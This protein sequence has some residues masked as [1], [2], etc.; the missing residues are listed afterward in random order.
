ME[1]V[2]LRKN[3]IE[4]VSK[5]VIIFEVNPF[6]IKTNKKNEQQLITTI[7]KQFLDLYLDEFQIFILNRYLDVSRY[8]NKKSKESSSLE[9][10]Y[11]EQLMS[12]LKDKVNKNNVI[13]EIYYFVAYFEKTKDSNECI[14][15]ISNKLSVLNKN[16]VSCKLL[17]DKQIL[18]VLNLSLFKGY[19]E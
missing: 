17:N 7:Y 3:Y 16:G 19:N 13:N 15:N 5:N 12:Y 11:K 9:N 1:I 2:A 10:E 4:L 8:F 6:N 18:E 14:N